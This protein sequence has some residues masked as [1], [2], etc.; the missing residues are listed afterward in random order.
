MGKNIVILGGGYAG[1]VAAKKLEKQYKKR[2]D[3]SITLIDKQPFHTILT[4]LHEVAGWRV[5]PDSVRVA[6][7]KI[8][9]ASKVKV[10][11][12]AIT[13]VD[14]K[15]SQLTSATKTYGYDYLV[16][17]SGADPEFFGIQGVKENSFTLWSFDDAVKLRYHIEEVFEKAVAEANH[18]KRRKML[19]FVVAGAGFT[20]IEMAGELLEWRDVMCAKWL[21]NKNEVRI[22]IVEAMSNILPMFEEGLRNKVEGYLRDHGV[23]LL[24]GTMIVGAEPNTVKLKD[25]TSLETETFIWTAGVSGSNFAEGLELSKGPYG[26]AGESDPTKKNRKGRLLVTDEMRSV[27]YPNVFPVGDNMWFVEGDG[28]LPQIV[29][30][31]MQTAE[32]AAHN[33]IV[34]IDGGTPKKFKSNFHGFLVSVGG[35]YGVS[36]AMGMRL[37]GAPAMFMKHFVSLHYLIGV[38]GLNQCWEYIKHEFLDIQNNRSFIRGIGSYK[39]RGY[40]PLLLRV[41]LGLTWLFSGI[42]KIAEGWLNW[43]NGSKSSWMFSP[44]V[45]QRGLDPDAVANA[46]S[47]AS[48]AGAAAADPVGIDDLFGAVEAVADAVADATGAASGASDGGS[49][50]GVWDFSK[51]IFSWMGGVASWMRT[52]MMD[53]MVAGLPFQLFQTMVLSAEMFIGL[54]LIFGFFTWFGAAVSVVMCIMFTLTGM[55]AWNQL[56]IMLAGLMFMGGGGR[57]FGLDC[58]VVPKA[59]KW[60]NGTTFARKHYWYHENPSKK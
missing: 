42:N 1:I 32:T 18:A 22:A 23:E 34:A 40:W 8:F 31:A 16:L 10:V 17:G 35:K 9:G 49:F 2:D 50:H 15:K 45:V 55:N 53:T 54:T 46:T 3:V 25:G 7:A 56:W 58:F 36:N 44:G 26:K 21:V 47:A 12:D 11:Y 48:G 33:I 37:S 27:D 28:P 60:W 6:F 4:E 19:T 41:W 24:T 39:T 5:E 52:T 20:G 51:A 59:K 57:A 13:G 29:E 14:F 30:T 38:A 43:T